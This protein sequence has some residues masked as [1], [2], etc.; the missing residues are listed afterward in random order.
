MNYRHAY[1]AGNFADVLKHATLALVIEHLKLKPAPFRVI[2]T[3][4]GTGV[5]DLHGDEATKTG[6]WR[7]GIARLLSAPKSDEI[8]DIL[9][10]YVEAVCAGNPGGELRTYPGSP[11]LVRRLI[12]RDDR[13][14][15]NELHPTDAAALAQL[16]ARDKQVKVTNLDGWIALKAFLPPKERRGLVLIDPPFEQAGELDRLLTGLR[17]IVRR[18]ATGSVILWYPIKSAPPIEAFERQLAASGV[19]KILRAELMIKPFHDAQSLCGTG[20]ILLNP[21]FTTVNKLKV[22][23]PFLADVFGH[24]QTPRWRLDWLSETGNSP[25]A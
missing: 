7:D 3:H 15:A 4:A 2:D 9:R 6:E 13:I 18:F 1:H 5:Y 16:F 12:R 23:L 22:L 25:S 14:I 19:D 24:T 20:L 10:P 8:N 17:E 21:P 11:L